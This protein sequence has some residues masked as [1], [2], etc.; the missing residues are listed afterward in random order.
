MSEERVVMNWLDVQKLK[1]QVFSGSKR[2]EKDQAHLEI[3]KQEIARAGIVSPKDVPPDVV[4]LNSEVLVRDLANGDKMIYRLVF[5]WNAD[6]SKNQVSVLA[7][8]GTALLGRRVGD[9]IR[10]RAPGRIREFQVE[11]VLYQ[12]EAAGLVA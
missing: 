9:S 7:P 1:A 5:P 8:I 3:L 4:T 6:I 10:F 2:H 11:K 12:P